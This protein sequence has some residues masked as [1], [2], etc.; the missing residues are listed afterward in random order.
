VKA[1][2]VVNEALMELSRILVPLNYVK[3]SIFD[4]DL[5]LKLPKIPKLAAIDDLNKTNKSEN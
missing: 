5:A 2:A 4:H 3:G 1:V